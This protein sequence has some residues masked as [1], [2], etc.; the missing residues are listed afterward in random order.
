M[1]ILKFGG[2][3]VGD[4]DNIRKVIHV[5]K[6]RAERQP[7]LVFSAMGD[8]TDRLLHI[9]TRAAEGQSRG[10]PRPPRVPEGLSQ[11]HRGPA[12]SR[13]GRSRL[14][15]V[16][17]RLRG[18]GGRGSRTGGPVGFLPR[19]A[20]PPPRLR[21][22][23]LHPHSHGDFPPGGSARGVDRR[24]GRGRHRRQAHAGRTPL[25]RDPEARGGGPPPARSGR[26]DSRDPGVPR[27]VHRR[28][29]DH[30]GAR[31]VPTSPRR[32]WGRPWGRKRS[33]YGP[34]WTAS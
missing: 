31:R 15:A 25:R 1:R 5:V 2:T 9:G 29:R 6:S 30:V 34:T 27:T 32:S 24:A 3:S 17:G 18:G 11:E 33:R 21:R 19:R 23:A 26:A 14:G 22:G 8:T 12:A 10:E 16:R 13:R 28:T 7:I 20:G 4:P